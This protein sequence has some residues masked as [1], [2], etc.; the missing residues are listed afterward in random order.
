MSLSNQEIRLQVFQ[1]LSHEDFTTNEV[2]TEGEKIAQWV[3]NGTAQAERI[4][5][6][7]P[8]PG[9]KPEVEYDT[10][11]SA[12]IKVGQ[13]ADVYALNHPTCGS[14]QVFTSIVLK[15]DDT[16][17]VFETLNTRYVPAGQKA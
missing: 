17:G 7:I 6:V 10:S 2:I 14:G 12:H 4:K 5:P 13:A 11:R 15:Y 1:R 8:Q 3:I 16:T 9:S